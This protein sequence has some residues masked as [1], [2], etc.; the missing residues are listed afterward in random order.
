MIEL[1]YKPIFPCESDVDTCKIEWN[2]NADDLKNLS[3]NI[4]YGWI[5]LMVCTIVGNML[6]F[7]GFGTS[8]EKINRRVRDSA[9]NSLL[10]QEI[11]FF[12]MHTVG[13]LCT[14]IEE[15]AAMIHSFSGE[16]VRALV[17]SLSSVAV[18]LLLALIYM[19]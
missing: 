13:N 10:R 4:T 3:I 15:D 14:Q 18:G 5:S 6:L 19:W 2:S 17:V 16:P 11:G 8:S 9:F 7:Y 1:L 12:D